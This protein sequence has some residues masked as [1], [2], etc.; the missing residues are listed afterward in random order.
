MM[1]AQKILHE[2]TT[3]LSIQIELLNL[4][5]EQMPICYFRDF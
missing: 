1:P 3:Q 2:G 5:F 4:F